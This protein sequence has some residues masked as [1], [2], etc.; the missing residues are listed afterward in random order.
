[1]PS[2]YAHPAGREGGEGGREEKVCAFDLSVISG[3]GHEGASPDEQAVYVHTPFMYTHAAGVEQVYCGLETAACCSMSR[4]DIK[5][6][7]GSR[8][9][10]KAHETHC[11]REVEGYE[12]GG[13]GYRGGV[14]SI[15]CVQNRG[16][17]LAGHTSCDFK[18]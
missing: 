4:A 14:F 10:D 18:T 1:M 12:C 9:A 16:E 5:M 13:G 2:N 15:I 6:S 3:Q 11:G 7:P 8:L 17:R